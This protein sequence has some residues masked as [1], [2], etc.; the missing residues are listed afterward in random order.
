MQTNTKILALGL[1]LLTGTSTANN[2]IGKTVPPFPTGW[3]DEGGSC[4]LDC[5]YSMGILKKGKE[6]LVYFGKALPKTDTGKSRWQVLDQMPY[7]ETREGFEVVYGSCESKGI[8]DPSIIA[9]VKFTET[10][11]LDQ[12]RFT[13]KANTAKGIFETISTE[14]IRCQNEG[15]GL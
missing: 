12:V 9:L 5:N 10:E 14:G 15:W 6:R 2:L 1:M 11:W 3:Q 8:A 4:V 13:Y 7:P